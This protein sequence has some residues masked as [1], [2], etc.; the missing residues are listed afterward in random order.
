MAEL[1]TIA[2]PYAEAVFRL[3]REQ[4]KLA[5]WSE[6]LTLL[7]SIAQ[8]EQMRPVLASPRPAPAQLAALFMDIAGEALDDAA[9]N[10]VRLLADNRRLQCLVAVHDQYE[11]LRAEEEGTL[12]AELVSA[13]PVEDA[14]RDSLGE[15]LSVRL[16]RKVTLRTSVD[17][18]LLG[19]AVIRA[20]DMV[21]DG[22]VRGRLQRLATQLSR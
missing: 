14:V 8:D 6:V 4:N 3:A 7:S 15:A 11:V 5:E 1:S 10:L 20:G 12:S 17:P 22:S 21:I 13:K 19:G 9:R 16:K 2:R 18:S